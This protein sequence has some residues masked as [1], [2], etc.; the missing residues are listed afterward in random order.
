MNQTHAMHFSIISKNMFCMPNL[1]LWNIYV[2]RVLHCQN[3]KIQIQKMCIKVHNGSN[4]SNTSFELF[5]LEN[6]QYQLE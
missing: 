4:I 5:D 3:P 2:L 6:V 1:S